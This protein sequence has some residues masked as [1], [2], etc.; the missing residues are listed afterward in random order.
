MAV[1]I[2]LEPNSWEGTQRLAVVPRTLRV[3]L[4]EG[5]QQQL[6]YVICVFMLG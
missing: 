1:G 6:R 5:G 2:G 4:P 3:Y